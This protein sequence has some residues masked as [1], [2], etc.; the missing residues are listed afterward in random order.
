MPASDGRIVVGVIDVSSAGDLICEGRTRMTEGSE[1]VPGAEPARAAA[2]TAVARV[3][4]NLDE[5]IT[6]E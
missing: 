3:L 5:F 4:I 1:A 6:R 2:W